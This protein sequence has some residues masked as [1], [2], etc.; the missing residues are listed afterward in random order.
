M[1]SYTTYF[2][3]WTELNDVIFSDFCQLITLLIV[4]QLSEMETLLFLLDDVLKSA[5]HASVCGLS[6]W[7]DMSILRIGSLP[8]TVCYFTYLSEIHC[9]SAQCVTEFGC[10]YLYDWVFFPPVYSIQT[11]KWTAEMETKVIKKGME[12]IQ[13]G[14]CVRFVPRTHQEDYIDIKPKSGWVL[15]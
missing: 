8:T 12:N 10:K 14:T 7:M 1:Q 9:N 13:K 5:L 15:F 11:L 4:L 3:K 2:N 6:Q